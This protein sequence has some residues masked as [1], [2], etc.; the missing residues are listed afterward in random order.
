M[1]MLCE[2]KRSVFGVGGE[3]TW[4]QGGMNDKGGIRSWL[5]NF[6][7]QSCSWLDGDSLALGPT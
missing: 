6:A 2:G 7:E 1:Y 3:V 5:L 4:I